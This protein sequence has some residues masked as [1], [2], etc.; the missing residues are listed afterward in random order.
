MGH[1]LSIRRR[2]SQSVVKRHGRIA[3]TSVSGTPRSARD[4]RVLRGVLA[5]SLALTVGLETGCHAEQ[6]WPLW[7][8]Y[9][10]TLLDS[11]G[12]VVDHIGQDRTTSEGQAYG[13][14]FALVDNDRSHFDQILNWTEANLAAGDLTLRLPAWSWG[15]NPD[16]S[17]KI[18]DPNPAADA[19]LWLAYDL[20]EAGRLWREPR[21]EKLGTIIAS[22]ISQGEVVDV[23]G[24][25]TTLLSGPRGFHPDPN[26]WLL[27]PSYFPPPLL[28]R[29]SKAMPEGPWSSILA[30]LPPLLAQ[31]SG[32]G[33]AMD[34]V[35]AG[36]SVRP[37]PTPAQVAAADP[38]AFPIGSYD[39]IRVYLWLGLSDKDTP[40]LRELFRGTAGMA[41]YMRS[42]VTPPLQVDAQGRVL[43]SNAPVGFSAALIP[44]LHAVGMKAQER[45]QSNR[46]AALK[47]AG[48]GLY[49]H[50]AAYYDQNL[51][52]FATGWTEGRFRFDRDGKLVV[53]WR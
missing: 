18:M 10:Q 47:D 4:A 16:G 31:G 43:S 1:P 42:Q 53:R 21:Y 25:G 17:W 24:L 50:Q 7:D 32:S 14:F 6:P 15:K 8:R 40:H 48:T 37:S 46:L 5:L 30:S 35:A 19:D 29:L 38:T 9:T 36:N 52:L 49:G 12:R 44:Y 45:D 26:T 34:W 23:P 11:Q 13:M 51:V 41:N 39:A 20:I 2:S 22:R 28:V 3:V 27:N 33:F